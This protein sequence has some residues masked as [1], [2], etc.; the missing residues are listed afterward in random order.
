M[1]ET[2]KYRVTVTNT[3]STVI[4]NLKVEDS[5]SEEKTRTISSIAVNGSESVEFTHIVTEA[6]IKEGKIVNTATADNKPSNTVETNTEDPVEKV[7]LNK[8]VTSEDAD[9]DGKYALGETISYKVT[10]TNIRNQTVSGIVVNDPVSEEKTKT[11]GTIAVNGHEDLT[12][13]HIVTEADIA[14]KKVVNVATSDKSDDPSNEVTTNTDDPVTELR[15]TKTAELIKAVGNK[16][17]NAEIGDTIHYVVKAKN[18]GNITLNR[19]T[20]KDETMNQPDVLIA[21]LEPNEETVAIEFN[22]VVVEGDIQIINGKVCIYNKATAQCQ[23]PIDPTK[24]IDDSSEKIVDAKGKYS[25]KVEYY[26]DNR[27]IPDVPPMHMPELELGTEVTSV[28]TDTNKKEGYKLDSSKGENGIVGLPLTIS[29]DESKNVIKV[30]YVRASYPYVINYYKDSISPENYIN[31]VENT[32]K[33]GEEVVADTTL[34]LPRGYKFEGTAPKMTI[35]IENNI[36][37]VVYVK[38]ETLVDTLKYTIKYY[39]KESSTASPVFADKTETQETAWQGLNQTTLTYQNDVETNKYEGYLFDK[40]TIGTTE[41]TAD[42]IPS[43]LNNGTIINVYY[44]KEIEKYTVTYYSGSTKLQQF[45]DIES[46]KTHNVQEFSAT[47]PEGKVFTGVWTDDQGNRYEVGTTITVTSNIN[48]YA[49]FKDIGEAVSE[50]GSFWQ[51]K[52]RSWGPSY[53][54]IFDPVIINGNI[55]HQA[56]Y[57]KTG[58]DYMDLQNNGGIDSIY[59]EDT[60]TYV[61]SSNKEIDI[62]LQVG[63]TYTFRV[64]KGNVNPITVE[65][66]TR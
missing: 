64:N 49:E 60:G 63:H 3:G 48:L 22:H 46:G 36:L 37:N 13:T 30:Y 56:F 34:Y 7:S 45:T 23:D 33:F 26:Y 25:Y 42:T 35:G 8:E 40:I 44:E 43:T 66:R 58:N 38:D 19:I 16:D 61:I 14:N 6:D 47:L 54:N 62:R 17:A 10:V 24:T 27:I 15:L 11:T 21:K 5:V 41:Y 39:K 53:Q 59:D 55:A 57:C 1:D 12:F 32:E 52:L 2:I 28:D 18:M 31:K 65:A 20:V 29:A 51:N 9:K 4:K 50:I